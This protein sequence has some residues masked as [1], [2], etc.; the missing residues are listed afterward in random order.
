MSEKLSGFGVTGCGEAAFS[1]DL[2]GLFAAVSDTGRCSIAND[3]L[4]M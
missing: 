3:L 2:P 4:S 1:A